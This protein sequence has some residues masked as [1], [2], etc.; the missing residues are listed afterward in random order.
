M[1][2]PLSIWSR[3]NPET[4]RIF[5][6]FLKQSD[7]QTKKDIAKN[8]IHWFEIAKEI[9][10]SIQKIIVQ[11]ILKN[12]YQWSYLISANSELLN[13]ITEKDLLN[14]IKNN[15]K[16][17]WKKINKIYKNDQNG[18]IR[19]IE[20]EAIILEDIADF[21]N[22]DIKLK[23]I[24][25]NPEL[26]RYFTKPDSKMQQIAAS[27]VKKENIFYTIAYYVIDDTMALNILYNKTQD[28]V[29]KEIIKRN[30]NFKN[31]ANIIIEVINE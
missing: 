2:N 21:L 28:I 27:N 1:K 29:I 3:E 15:K 14:L 22:Y 24:E 4:I 18:L 13:K 16:E 23:I 30:P 17:L 12:K 8:A 19:T 5:Q 26:I 25:N 6:E 10:P 31:D 11:S 9:N 20:A 7:Y